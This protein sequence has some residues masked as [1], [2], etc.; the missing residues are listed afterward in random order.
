MPG[1]FPLSRVAGAVDQVHSGKVLGEV[2]YS[3]IL[4]RSIINVFS[5]VYRSVLCYS[6][7]LIQYLKDILI[8]IHIMLYIIEIFLCL[9]LLYY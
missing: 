2:Y 7:I 4:I 6:D 5:Y 3:D 1:I 9:I 8:C